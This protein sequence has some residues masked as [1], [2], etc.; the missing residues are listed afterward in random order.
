[1]T[2]LREV[3][4]RWLR[5]YY[6]RR[7]GVLT[8]EVV[9]P[10]AFNGS[11]GSL[12]LPLSAAHNAPRWIQRCLLHPAIGKV[13]PNSLRPTGGKGNVAMGFDLLQ[14]SR[15]GDQGRRLGGLPDFRLI[16]TG[17]HTS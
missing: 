7:R 4:A 1:M 6:A 8:S 14:P 13:V 10:D 12:N 15:A 5:S 3:R 9:D 11:T 2:A 17:Q 16:G